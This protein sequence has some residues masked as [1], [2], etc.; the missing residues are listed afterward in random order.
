MAPTQEV[1]ELTP[2]SSP[3]SGFGAFHME[4]I[5]APTTKTQKYVPSQG[6]KPP[7]KKDDEYGVDHKI[8]IET[9]SDSRVIVEQDV[10][11]TLLWSRVRRVHKE[12]FSEFLG[13]FVLILFGDGVVAQ[14]VLSGGEKGDYQS[15]SWGWG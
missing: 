12:A 5:A 1:D 9:T 13:T 14:V 10:R 8:P 15:I 7:P 3:D 4:D 11:P 6:Q 2:Q